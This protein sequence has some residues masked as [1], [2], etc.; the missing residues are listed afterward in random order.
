MDKKT[1]T[2]ILDFHKH[3]AFPLLVGIGI[4]CIHFVITPIFEKSN[5]SRAGTI[6]WL[7]LAAPSFIL[8]IPFYSLPSSV[9]ELIDS[10]ILVIIFDLFSSLIY[11]VA[12]GVLVSKNMNLRNVG[13]ILLFLIVLF[14]CFL[15]MASGQSFA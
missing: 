12:A 10:S 1:F 7:I 3:P 13:F 14:G 9:S 5:F 8:K 15:L 4:A 6:I 2:R 11:G